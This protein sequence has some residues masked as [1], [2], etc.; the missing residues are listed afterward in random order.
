MNLTESKLLSSIDGVS[1]GFSDKYQ[2]RDP[3]RIAR[4]L[5]LKGVSL[6]KQVHGNRVVLLGERRSDE[7]VA[8]GDSLVTDIKGQGIGVATA[9]C[10][11]MLLASFDARVV[12]AV[13]AGWRGTLEGIVANTLSAIEDRY[14]VKPENIKA[15]IGPSIGSCCYEVG[16]DVSSLFLEK[17]PWSGE[18][19]FEKG[20]SKHLL[21]LRAANKRLLNSA[22]VFDIEVLDICTK[23]SENF[24]SYRRDGKGTGRQLSVIGITR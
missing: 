5:N 8:E 24:Y 23:C 3:S 7:G 13:H 20:D 22:G 12:A 18:I 14:G 2:G 6:L 15:A 4:G 1:H 10:V 11:P 21:D 16:E 19:L 9:D 17:Y